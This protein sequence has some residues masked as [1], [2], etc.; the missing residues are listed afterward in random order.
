MYLWERKR[1]GGVGRVKVEKG[2]VLKYLPVL[3]CFSL[4]LLLVSSWAVCS[5]RATSPCI[6]HPRGPGWPQCGGVWSQVWEP[7]WSSLGH[8]LYQ[9]C[10]DQESIWGGVE[11]CCHQNIF[12]GQGLWAICTSL[13]PG[14]QYTCLCCIATGSAYKII[15]M[16]LT[17]ANLLW[18][19]L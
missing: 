16:H 14:S 17:Q 9:Q 8:T 1:E 7:V 12:S 6:L 11:L 10:H 2:E 18:T 15:W 13:K 3:N 5:S 4:S 19:G